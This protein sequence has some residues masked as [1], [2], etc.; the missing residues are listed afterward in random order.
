MAPATPTRAGPAAGSSQLF[1]R[2][3]LWWP[4]LAFTIAFGVL[5]IF[6]LDLVLA[7][8]WYFSDHAAQW[9]GAGNGAWWARGILHTGGRWL[10]RGIAAGALAIWA[11]S[12]G[13]ARLH[14]WRR[15]AGFVF[16]AMLL[17]TLLVGSLK[18]VTNVDCPWD[19]AGFGGHNPY[20][21]LFADRPD[22][23][24]R[25]QCFPGA[26]ASSGFA[27]IC[28]YFAFRDRSRGAARWMLAAAIAI[29]IAFSIGQEARGAHFF[30]HDLTS[31]AIVWCTQLGLYAVYARPPANSNASMCSGLCMRYPCA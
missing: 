9:L 30:S 21:A 23:L 26:H 10:V 1:W 2:Q 29:G 14:D 5:E 28:F 13:V 4:L 12:F 8:E 27:L 7:R 17:A 3:H 19:L 15:T 22:A 20:V 11:L 31:A 25:A 6:S 24:P 18:A 16:L